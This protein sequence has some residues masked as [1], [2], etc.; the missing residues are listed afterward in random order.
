MEN[1]TVAI[2]DTTTAWFDAQSLTAGFIFP[3]SI[4][5]DFSLHRK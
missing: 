3:K 2:D 5:A 4:R 1:D